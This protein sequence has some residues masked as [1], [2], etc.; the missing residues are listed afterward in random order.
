MQVSTYFGSGKPRNEYL[1]LALT[2]IPQGLRD[3]EA[4]L[5]TTRWF[6][7]RTMTPT[8]ATY[9]FAA[10]YRHAYIEAFKRTRDIE[11][12]ET[13]NPFTPEDIFDSRELTVM[14][15]ARQAADSIGCKYDFFLR[16]AFLRFEHR[17]W[18]FFPRA[19]HLS[20]EELVL[21]ARDAWKTVCRASLQVAVSPMYK[22]GAFDQLPE[23]NEYYTWLCDQVKQREHPYMALSQL[24]YTDHGLP[25]FF[26]SQH[27]NE[28]TM[29]RSKTFAQ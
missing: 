29:K 3:E 13:V 4:E 26:A 7:Y 28:A 22:S 10:E 8:E 19:N 21:D 18:R 24:V 9:L 17:G 11:R 20:S 25:E 23:Q 14:W 16:F 2:K 15:Q 1:Q 27:F 6:D 5:R 12:A